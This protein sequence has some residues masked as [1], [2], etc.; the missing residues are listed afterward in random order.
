TIARL[1]SNFT[2]VSVPDDDHGPSPYRRVRSSATTRRSDAMAAASWIVAVSSLMDRMNRQ[3]LIVALGPARRRWRL[4]TKIARPRTFVSTMSD[5]IL[6]A[7]SR[8]LCTWTMGRIERTTNNSV[9]AK[10]ESADA[11]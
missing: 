2:A 8:R 4:P 7:N 1:M 11:L 5:E 3:D 9:I 10:P 6:S